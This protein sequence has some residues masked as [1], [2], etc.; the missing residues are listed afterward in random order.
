MTKKD[1]LWMTL[2]SIGGLSLLW[3]FIITSVK[4][5]NETGGFVLVF[6]TPVVIITT[7]GVLWE[8]GISWFEKA[9]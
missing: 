9:Q 6:L 1:R 2:I 4:P 7:L 8:V 3:F 5:D